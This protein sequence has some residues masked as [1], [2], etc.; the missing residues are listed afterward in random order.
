VGGGCLFETQIVSFGIGRWVT[1]SVRTISG[2]LST[3][4]FPIFDGQIVL[5]LFCLTYQVK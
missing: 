1:I 3:Y 4:H 2:P 5:A